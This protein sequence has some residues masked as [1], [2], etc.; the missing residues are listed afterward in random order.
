MDT[1]TNR[2]S[3]AYSSLLS[4]TRS[5]RHPTGVS[6]PRSLGDH[7]STIATET[8]SFS[9][10]GTVIDII[11]TSGLP[12]PSFVGL[13]KV[14]LGQGSQFIVHRQ[15][16]IWSDDDQLPQ[17]D[18]PIERV[19]V[20]RPKFDLSS[21]DRVDIEQTSVRRHLDSI[22]TEIKAL[23]T[24][25][26]RQH[27]NI[28]KLLSWTI[29]N[30]NFHRPLGL[31]MELAVSD[32]AKLLSSPDHPIS[33]LE[34][35][36]VCSEIAAGIDAI[37]DCQMIHGDLKPENVLIFDK[38][39]TL[40]AMLADFGLATDASQDTGTENRLRLTGT[41]GWQAPE[42]VDGKL[43][44]PE[45]ATLADSYSCGLV[46]WSAMFGRG[47]PPPLRLS[48][49]GPE[50]LLEVEIE[51]IRYGLQHENEEATFPLELAERALRQL[52]QIDPSRRPHKLESLFCVNG[53]VIAD[54]RALDHPAPDRKL[55]PVSVPAPLVK[56][57]W[58]LPTLSDNFV[59][60]LLTRFKK[61]PHN[62]HPRTLFVCF[63]Y[64]TT[65][66]PPEMRERPVIDILLASASGGYP[67][68]Q[69][70]IPSIFDYFDKDMPAQVQC[71]IRQWLESAVATGSI[72][73]LRCLE[74]LDLNAA[75]GALDAFRDRGGYG[76]HVHGHSSR[77]SPLHFLAAHGSLRDLTEFMSSTDIIDIDERTSDDETPLYLACARGSWA[78]ANHLLSCGADASV[79]CTPFTITCLHWFFVFP[80]SL[81]RIV[82][83]TLTGKGARIDAV[84]PI[85]VPFYHYP[86]TLPAGSPLHWAVVLDSEH[87]ISTLLELGADPTIRDRSDPYRYNRQVRFLGYWHGL[88]QDS[89]S[90]PQAETQGLSPLDYA[91]LNHSPCIFETLLS[92]TRKLSINMNDTD[93]EGFTVVHRLGDSQIR[94]TRSQIQLSAVPFR[95]NKAAAAER[96]HRTISAIKALG[97]NL[98]KLTTP[99]TSSQH[100]QM[101]ISQGVSYTPLMLAALNGHSEVVRR[102]GLSRSVI[103]SRYHGTALQNSETLLLGG[104]NI[105]HRDRFGNTALIVAAYSRCFDILRLFIS[106]G[107]DLYE[108]E[109][110]PGSNAEGNHWLA[111]IPT[112]DTDDAQF[113]MLIDQIM[114][115]ID[116]QSDA[117]ANKSRLM[118]IFERT[119]R[120][121]EVFLYRLA[122]CLM[123]SSIKT[124]VRHGARVNA[125]S[126]TSTTR[127]V[128]GVFGK[129]TWRETP[130]EGVIFEK[131][132][133]EALM[134]QKKAYSDREFE[135]R[136]T[137]ADAVITFLRD[138]GGVTLGERPRTVFYANSQNLS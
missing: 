133:I 33:F 59:P 99:Q 51:H 134:S 106:Y 32:L 83:R 27:P 22:I 117:G 90:L 42:V 6:I 104:A 35:Y 23:T 65:Y 100:Q 13:P 122:S 105:H 60:L 16:V 79:S 57:S 34:R 103:G 120:M 43:L 62:L 55:E 138:V 129:V 38:G 119:N 11:Q 1:D 3:L 74:K 63:L 86:F 36:R 64:L 97:G 19:A 61:Y 30:E 126:T 110:E 58:E 17:V 136:C 130:L 73:A 82:A 15:E 95:G 118:D 69:A 76:Q 12:G 14:Y 111:I 39:G 84:V 93:E 8:D 21:D 70:V 78:I 127:K 75:E 31:I 45:E 116:A 96:L 94:R 37:H 50:S 132:R 98:D 40:V 68:A 115:K 72:Q 18:H 81:Q 66:D 25:L 101:N 91:A 46:S 137:R 24:P 131:K 112:S 20:K 114:S 92:C 56:L 125:P 52:L 10:I 26:L 28:V 123:L 41:P 87:A 102:A 108:T 44:S 80:T 7:Q 54:L 67:P 2:T 89:Y 107:A 71:L 128:D 109:S 9:A 113:S 135:E 85:P 5:S 4:R 121:G 49:D 48:S 77:F 124:M 47:S 29:D 53:S 88:N